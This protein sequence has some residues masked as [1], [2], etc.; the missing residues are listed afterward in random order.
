[1]LISKYKIHKELSSGCFG[2]IYLGYHQKT[3]EQVAIKEEL[4]TNVSTLKHEAKIYKHLADVKQVPSIKWFGATNTHFYMV[5]P[6]LDNTLESYKQQSDVFPDIP[7]RYITKMIL[8]VLKDVHERQIVHCDIKPSN[9]MFDNKGTLFLIDFGFARVFSSNDKSSHSSIGTLNY[10][11][12]R[13]H[14]KEPK[15][16]DDLESVWYIF[17]IYIHPKFHGRTIHLS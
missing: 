4:K 3:H 6:L 1:M 13:V 5:L 15:Y 17:S 14:M 11:S 2:K 7:L 10:M 8:Q 9:F 16:I 12:R